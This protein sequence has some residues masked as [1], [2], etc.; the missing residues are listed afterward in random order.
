MQ[1][2][3][4]QLS[5]DEGSVAAEDFR[6][7]G[8]TIFH[9]W[10]LN[11]EISRCISRASQWAFC[12][13]WSFMVPEEA[14]R[15]DQ[16]KPLQ[17]CSFQILGGRCDIFQEKWEWEIHKWTTEKSNKLN[18]SIDTLVYCS[19]KLKRACNTSLNTQWLSW[20]YKVN[21]PIIR[22]D[23]LWCTMTSVQWIYCCRS[24]KRNA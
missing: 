11:H 8:S 5:S 6:H 9:D 18:H 1:P 3:D 17:G 7:H 21:G 12:S 24:L 22:T 19:C 10:F 13:H 16:A 2:R 4:V 20:Q 23:L 15:W 14:E